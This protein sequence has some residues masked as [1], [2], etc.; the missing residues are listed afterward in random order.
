MLFIILFENKKIN[1]LF[2]KSDK[3]LI[4]GET[5]ILPTN[6]YIIMSI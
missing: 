2:S 3:K 6:I 4:V 5:L 1:I